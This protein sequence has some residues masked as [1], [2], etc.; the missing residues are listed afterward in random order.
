MD[1]TSEAAGAIPAGDREPSQNTKAN[2]YQ[3]SDIE[4]FVNPV[5]DGIPD[6]SQYI[7]ED[8]AGAEGAPVYTREEALKASQGP[9][10]VLYGAK[11]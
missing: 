4:G 1:F 3:P 10:D 7:P 2:K 11:K 9:A 8:A 5:V 6:T